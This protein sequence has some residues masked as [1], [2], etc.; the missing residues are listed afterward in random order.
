MKLEIKKTTDPILRAKTEEVT[1]FGM[2]FQSF[3]DDMIETMRASN[4]VGLAAP[5]VNSAKKVIVLEYKAE[6]DSKF[7]SF[8]LTVICNPKIVSS[9]ETSRNMVEGCLS[10]PGLEIIVKRPRDITVSGQDRF[11]NKLT[12]EAESLF[13]RVLQ[14][15]TDHLNSVLLIDHIRKIDVVFIGTGT[16]GTDALEILAIDPQYK[17]RAV[18][19]GNSQA[20]SRKHPEKIN[21]IE[22]I[23]KIYNL[24]LIK[25][26]NIN[27]PEIVEKIKSL[28]PKLG[29]MADFGQIIS[30]DVISIPEFGI[31]NIHPSLL[32][33]HRGPSPIQ[34]TI[35]DG[36]KT[37]GVSLILTGTKMDAGDIIS[38]VIIKLRGTETTTLLKP[39]LA[40]IGASL[41]ANSIPY[42]LTKDLAPTP[43]E[44]TKATY[45]RLFKK[46]DGFVDKDTPKEIVDRKIRAFSDWPKTF[47]I[48][49]GKKVQLIAGHFEKDSSYTLD[50]VKPEGKK[51]MTYE[52]FKRG[53]H[54]ELTFS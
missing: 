33:K 3:V 25:T 30:Q 8:P 22:E 40:E 14:H 43:Q 26:E 11:G 31:I 28:K 52:D 12:I 13:S 4:G 38:Q 34:Q 27:S 6:E 5:Q 50:R 35:L 32:P 54:S 21:P 24:P 44:E 19:T 23:A 18:I 51:E 17:I 53:Y 1:D 10:F 9:S 37:T 15:E 29:I 39:Y 46:E 2:E 41:L 47:T 45:N 48:V 49:N 20:I 7:K 42:Y 36:D 16:L